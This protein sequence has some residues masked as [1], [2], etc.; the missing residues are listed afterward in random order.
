MENFKDL[1]ALKNAP[2]IDT[3]KNESPIMV[4]FFNGGIMQRVP[5]KHTD[6]KNVFECIKNGY[7]RK[8]I[9]NLREQDDHIAFKRDKELLPYFTANGTF[10]ERNMKGLIT[11]SDLIC[12]D[13]DNVCYV[14]DC[15]YL[16]NESPY[17]FASFVSPSGQGIKVFC[18]IDNNI[19][20]NAFYSLYGYYV[21][22]C[23]L[24]ADKKAKDLSR[25]C[26]VSYDANLYHNP[27]A[28]I[29]TI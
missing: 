9:E 29:W 8:K 10:S 3:P 26:F 13:F 15:I 20:E 1:G 6:I 25:A 11:Y 28:S 27:N 23:G 24:R 7:W 14:E 19:F 18:K 21:A 4:S 17:T 12:L 5:T 2:L 16:I 22:L